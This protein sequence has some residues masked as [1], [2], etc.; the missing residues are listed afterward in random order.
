MLRFAVLLLLALASAAAASDWS[1]ANNC[2]KLAPTFERD[3]SMLCD[4]QQ[5]VGAR[6]RGIIARELWAADL[7]TGFTVAFVVFERHALTAR[8]LSGHVRSYLTGAGRRPCIVLVVDLTRKL[9]SAVRSPGTAVPSSAVQV[10]VE[11][12]PRLLRDL[13]RDKALATLA[14][15]LTAEL[16]AGKRS[17]SSSVHS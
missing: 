9:A 4:L 2:V 12:T 6:A 8:D 16:I 1:R 10:V 5:S 3:G 15:L 7:T 17:G 13:P 14:T 11:E